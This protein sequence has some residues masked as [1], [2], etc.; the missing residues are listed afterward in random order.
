MNFNKSNWGKHNKSSNKSAKNKSSKIAQSSKMV[1]NPIK[2][3]AI[4]L[5]HYLNSIMPNEEKSDL[6]IMRLTDRTNKSYKKGH[7]KISNVF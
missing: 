2:L 4:N 5:N 1:S 6:S 7:K 3:L